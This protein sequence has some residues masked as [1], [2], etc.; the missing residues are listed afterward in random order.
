MFLFLFVIPYITI[1]LNPGDENRKM[2]NTLLKI[3]CIPQ[4]VLF[5]IELTQIWKQKLDYFM[6]WNITDFIM[7][8]V[9]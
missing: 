1:I 9:F 8:V 5:S 7:F 4:Y 2:N 3:C 6:G